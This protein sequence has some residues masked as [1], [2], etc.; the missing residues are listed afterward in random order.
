MQIRALLIR[1]WIEDFSAFDLWMRPLGLMRLATVL[2]QLGVHVELLDCLDRRSPL[3]EGL[4]LPQRHRLNRYDC[5][6][7]YREEIPRPEILKDIPR[8]FKQHGVPP[9]RVEQWLRAQRSPDM[10]FVACMATYWY[11]GA[12][13]MVRLCKAIWPS[14]PV[15][16]G[17]VYPL[18]CPE[19]ACANSG[20]D[21]IAPQPGWESVLNV[22]AHALGNPG[23]DDI[24][25][26]AA[27]PIELAFDLLSDRRSIPILTRT[28]C[29]FRCT[30]C[31]GEHLAPKSV[32][33]P[34]EWVIGQI[35][36]GLSNEGI[37]DVAFFDDALLF[38][39]DRY[40][41]PFFEQIIRTNLPVRF[42]TPNAL[43]ARY[44]DR[45]MADLMR[46]AGVCMVRLGLESDDTQFQVASGGKITND[47]YAAAMENLKCAGFT[48]DEIGTYILAGLPGQSL[49][50]LRRTATF[51]HQLGSQIRLALY[52]P[53]PK[54]AL[55]HPSED[56]RFDPTSDPLLQNDSLTPWRSRLYTAEEF[57]ELKHWADRMNGLG[58]WGR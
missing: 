43:H 27:E 29:P 51:V 25:N 7:L 28:G 15:T 10:V 21:L 1:P 53:T 26:A 40:A 36:R 41:K 18:L 16:L 2:R 11:T 58:R 48:A 45:E 35:Q 8:R 30:Y 3:L 39:P 47:E 38:D 22:A 37:T 9:E 6:H 33:F 17:G 14:V 56:F 46:R 13:R 57:H 31:A 32:P 55:F 24:R 50:S 19:H 42:H 44:I 23:S 5:G 54:T 49:E 4:P 52:S 34:P 12:W 20:A